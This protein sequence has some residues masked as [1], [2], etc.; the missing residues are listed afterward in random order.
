MANA[1]QDLEAR[2]RAEA[3]AFH[4][5]EQCSHEQTAFRKRFI[6][7]G[8]AQFRQQCLLCGD[9]TSNA[10]PKSA[11]PS[12]ADPGS[13]DETLAAAFRASREAKW[14]EMKARHS[15]ERAAVYG[16]YLASPKWRT[17]RSKVLKRAN[18]ICEGCA[19]QPA[20]EVHHL[21]YERWGREMLFD[22]VALC[23]ACHDSVHQNK[24]EP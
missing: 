11:I 1:L 6:K 17:L 4:D 7:G 13:W 19:E 18:G 23:G 24:H 8:G 15:A 5:D 22:L 21:T 16:S 2:Q 10:L 14:L 20:E 9:S 12:G 3:S